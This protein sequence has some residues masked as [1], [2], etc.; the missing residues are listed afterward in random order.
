VPSKAK[1][2]IEKIIIDLNRKL[3]QRN[4]RVKN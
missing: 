1:K 4:N 2:E 3:M